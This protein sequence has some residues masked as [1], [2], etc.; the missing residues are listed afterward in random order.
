MTLR[1]IVDLALAR[2]QFTPQLITETNSIEMMKHIVQLGQAVTFL[3]PIDVA[4]DRALGRVR[5]LPI[6][7][8][9][10]QELSLVAHARK[11]IDPIS[12]RFAEHLKSSLAVLAQGYDVE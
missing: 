5:Y 12:S 9:K 4:E 3:N 10:T 6:A 1:S 8:A 11:A 7:E 2:L